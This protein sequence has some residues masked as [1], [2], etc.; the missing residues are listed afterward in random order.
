[1]PHS[2]P[3]ACLSRIAASLTKESVEERLN[4][5]EAQSTGQPVDI[6]ATRDR[7]RAKNETT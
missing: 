3:E 2:N 6:V 7:A 5:R 4:Q 1:M